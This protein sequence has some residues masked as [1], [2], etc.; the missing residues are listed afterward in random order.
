MNKLLFLSMLFTVALCSAQTTINKVLQD[1]STLKV[2]N[3]IDLELIKSEDQRIEITG[4]KTDKVVI[5]EED[6]TLKVYLRFPETVAEGKV[7][8]TLYFN[9]NIDVID[10]N[11]GAT[12]TGKNIDQTS[13][14]VK[15]QEGAFINLVVA[16]K[17]LYVK[18]TSGGVIKLSGTTQNQDVSVDLGGA[19][20]GYKLKTSHVSTVK[21]GSGA[22]AEVS[23]GETLDARVTFG[24][25]IF[26]KGT[27]E[28]LKDKKIIGGTI[29]QRN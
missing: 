9:K 15:A 2:Y 27:P 3:G 13:L 17:H 16:T 8:A 25:T 19:Y 1:F 10:A 20:H 23:V 22:K 26:Y 12:L 21:A 4:E 18:S 5:K 28:V 14:E 24:G 29:E 6:K 11:E 7:K